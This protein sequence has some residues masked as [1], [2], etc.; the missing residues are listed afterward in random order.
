MPGDYK[1]D[2]E[3]PLPETTTPV[4]PP[5]KAP[6]NVG[7]G[8]SDNQ[9]TNLGTL[10]VPE[11]ILSI[12]QDAAAKYQ[13]PVDLLLSVMWQESKYNPNARNT[14]NPGGGID[15]GIAQ[16]NSK[17]HPDVTDKQAYDPY[18]AIDMLARDTAA[19]HANMLR[20]GQAD[21]KDTWWD[22]AANW[23]RAVHDNE[24]TSYRNI[25]KNWADNGFAAGPKSNT[26]D[27]GSGSPHTDIIGDFSDDESF[28]L[29]Q[30]A[31]SIYIKLLGRL[32]TEAEYRDIYGN[33]WTEQ[34]LEDH[35]RSTTYGDSKV[36]VG[37]AGDIREEAHRQ[38]KAIL[39]RDADEGE[40]QW[41]IANQIPSTHVSAYYEQIRDKAPWAADPDTYR[42]MRHRIWMIM[43]QDY[44][45]SIPEKDVSVAM[46]NEA[47]SGKFTDSQIK[48]SIEKTQAPNQ[49]TGVT[50]GAVKRVD[51][52]S[53][54]IWDSYFPGTTM[55]E[56]ERKAMIGMTPAQMMDHIRSLPS[57]ENPAIQAG[58][59]HDAK[60]GVQDVY[61]QMGF[62]GRQ[63]TP[64]DIT[65]AVTLKLDKEGIWQNLAKKSDLLAINPGLPYHL[66]RQRYY[67][68]RST[69][70]KSYS[71]IFGK[72]GE[73]V[74][75]LQKKVDDATPGAAPAE[76]D[77]I[78]AI[79]KQGLGE[80]EV[81]SNFADYFKR[82]G[83]APSIDEVNGFKSKV[84]TQYTDRTIEPGYQ[85]TDIGPV[86]PLLGGPKKNNLFGTAAG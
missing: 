79:F 38:A 60:I 28:A 12:V 7:A 49:A 22:A 66:D 3:H 61:N 67:N 72:G 69:V 83:R 34:D 4:P 62:V 8:G 78:K 26:T 17:Y 48:E 53:K 32:P 45:I 44:G 47:T 80:N 76:P 27:R 43:A 40:I 23:H 20:N 75:L 21:N 51:D 30:V 5:P 18:F 77:Y 56:A 85:E 13:V 41:L 84:T 68:E 31:D 86:A 73:N 58:P 36:T 14:K 70:E 50:V 55:P 52:V 9:P 15:R 46:V 19:T 42:N 63:P 24:W 25:V 6:P 29:H 59:Y 1:W 10:N 39:G 71:D 65:Q 33:H 16:I 11:N 81:R 64:D 74:D 82:L 57:L 37:T 35:L 2:L 54:G